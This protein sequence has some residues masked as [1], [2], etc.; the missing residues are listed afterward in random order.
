MYLKSWEGNLFREFV[1]WLK[2]RDNSKKKDSF[3]NSASIQTTR[4]LFPKNI[5]EQIMH[6]ILSK[7]LEPKFII[8]LA[9][10]RILKV[11]RSKEVYVWTSLVVQWLRIRLPMQGTWVLALGRED[12]TCLRATKPMRHNYWACTLEPASHNYWACAPQLLK[13]EH[14]RAHALQQEKRPQWEAH[15][16][17]RKSRPRSPQ[18]EKAC[19]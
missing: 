14:P 16:P 19:V 7:I 6:Q 18:L 9:L 12:P 11:H 2:T 10:S 8:S 13:P 15:A 1:K 17:Q 4:V 3:Q 5:C